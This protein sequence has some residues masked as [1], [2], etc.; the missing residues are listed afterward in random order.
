MR[1]LLF[2]LFIYLILIIIIYII[3]N[4]IKKQYYNGDEWEKYRLADF[5]NLPFK[6]W[7]NNNDL[8]FQNKD[9][10]LSR[11]FKKYNK[12]FYMNY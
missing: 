12:N 2:L 10:I 1:F 9:N 8:K 6:F 5:I 4:N 7:Y 3:N 11:Y